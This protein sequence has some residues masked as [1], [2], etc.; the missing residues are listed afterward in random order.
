MAI[1]QCH[2]ILTENA[3]CKQKTCCR[4]SLPSF[5]ILVAILNTFAFVYTFT[6][7]IFFIQSG[8]GDAFLAL[9]WALE[10]I[11][12]SVGLVFLTLGI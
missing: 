12:V 9:S 2:R 3:I 6:G 7:L 4:T 5:M 8:E 1:Y 10:L 11:T